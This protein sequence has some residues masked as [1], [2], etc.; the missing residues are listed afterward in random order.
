MSTLVILGLAVGLSMDAFAV[1]AATSVALR[2]VTPR[3]VFRF[4]FHFGLFQAMMPVLGW[5]AG[6]TVE[7][8]IR[9]WDHWVAFGL[10]AAVGGKSIYQ[11]LR[12]GE[13]RHPDSDPTRGLSLVVL[14][15]ATSLDAL[16]V[17]LSFAMVKVQIWY[18]VAIIGAVT[19]GLTTV[20]MVLGS[21]LGSRFGQ[22]V[23]VLGGLVLIGIGVKIL[24]SH[25]Q[26]GPT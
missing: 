5:L 10:L 24:M 20:G 16:A 18:P 26:G 9:A 14:S 7:R 13:G 11:A 21:R 17:G 2:K 19:A 6:L 3:H 8:H 23:E 25:W 1:A 4:A 15:F 12:S 22:R